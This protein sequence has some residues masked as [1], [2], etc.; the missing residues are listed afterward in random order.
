MY[1]PDTS[2]LRI[3]NWRNNYSPQIKGNRIVLED[4]E[5]SRCL[6]ILDDNFLLGTEWNLRYYNKSGQEIWKDACTRDRLEC[7]SHSQR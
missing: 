7:K 2:S 1:A 3:S 5:T 4:H 6:A